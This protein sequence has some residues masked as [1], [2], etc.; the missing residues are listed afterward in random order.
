[1]DEGEPV[2]PGPRIDD[3]SFASLWRHVVRHVLSHVGRTCLTMDSPAKPGQPTGGMLAISA[4]SGCR[5][6]TPA[7]GAERGLYE[8]KG[9]VDVGVRRPA[10]LPPGAARVRPGRSRA[11]LGAGAYVVRRERAVPDRP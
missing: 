1:M 10:E 2:L 7:S 6:R 3:H 9:R 8:Q 5:S 11:A 4:S